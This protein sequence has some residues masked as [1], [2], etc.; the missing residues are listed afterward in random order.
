MYRPDRDWVGEQ[1]FSRIHQS[2][3]TSSTVTLE[4]ELKQSPAAIHITDA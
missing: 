1:G 3:F 4:A 2:I